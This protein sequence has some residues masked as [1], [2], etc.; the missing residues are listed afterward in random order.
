MTIGRV[1]S[2]G[3]AG[4]RTQSFIT[5]FTTE[6][7]KGPAVLFYSILLLYL[8]QAHI[9]RAKWVTSPLVLQ[10]G[11]LP[12]IAA[13]LTICYIVAVLI[14]YRLCI[15]TVLLGCA[16][17]VVCVT[18]QR[19]WMQMRYEVRMVILAC[20]L[21]L[22]AA[23]KAYR[24]IAVCYL[25]VTAAGIALTL[26][27][28]LFH[29]TEDIVLDD[30]GK[31]MLVGIG[32]SMGYVHPNTFAKYVFLLCIL[33][34][35]L[36][37]QRR[38]L[39]SAL[40]CWDGALFIW[41]VSRNRML[42]LLLVCFPLLVL[43]RRFLC[44][45]EASHLAGIFKK[46]ADLVLIGMPYLLLALSVFLSSHVYG[47]TIRFQGTSLW[48][49]AS[50]FEQAG[51]A[52]WKYGIHL[53]GQSLDLS[54]QIAMSFN[55]NQHKLLAVDNGYMFYLLTRGLVYIL[56]LLAVPACVHAKCI[57]EKNSRVLFISCLFLLCGLMEA[58]PLRVEFN[59]TFLYLFARG[60]DGPLE[61]EGGALV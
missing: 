51:I 28:Q 19:F 52:L 15:W 47:M 5:G 53:F 54:G 30:P 7:K 33:I 25:A 4:N 14:R 43:C 11:T 45:T 6:W 34:W 37:L 1:G 48:T 46:C 40:V 23:G 12:R 32:H 9:E 36:W 29:F 27:G 22:M 18:Q 26:A 17:A 10:R 31:L 38:F 41:F 49:M 35:Y 59:L 20:A 24:K 13:F 50:R 57:R 61:K 60:V 21:I 39:L 8:A 42:T 3:D 56:V 16:L 2:G 44:R 55:G 58:Y